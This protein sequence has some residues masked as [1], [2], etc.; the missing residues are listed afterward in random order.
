MCSKTFTE[1]HNVPSFA[2]E[3]IESLAALAKLSMREVATEDQSKE[4]H[5]L[6]LVPHLIE[7]QEQSK[8][9]SA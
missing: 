4:R 5:I 1:P 7:Y 3:D 9:K 6:G 8:S 2:Q